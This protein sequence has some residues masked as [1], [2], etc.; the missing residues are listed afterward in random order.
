MKGAARTA[1]L[2]VLA[3]L[4]GSA[5]AGLMPQAAQTP[6]STASSSPVPS[7]PNGKLGAPVAMPAGFPAD[8]PVYP[9]S[10][11]TAAG[12]F[13]GDGSTN[14]G[15]EWQTMDA[16]DKVQAFFVGRLAAGDWSLVS[17]SGGTGTTPFSATFMR[18][19]DARIKGSLGVA[20][21]GV[22]KISLV[23]T[24]YP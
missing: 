6:T 10:R 8:F 9:A 14:W 5:C 1:G 12:K 3:L 21:S 11:L 7:A 19:S 18:R 13:A 2:A 20:V 22:T 15:M 17:H 4:V 23:L 24:T 16:R